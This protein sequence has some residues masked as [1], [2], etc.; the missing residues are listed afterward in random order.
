MCITIHVAK[1]TGVLIVSIR[2]KQVQAGLVFL[3]LLSAVGLSGCGADLGVADDPLALPGVA[4]HGKVHGGVYPIQKATIRLMETQSNGYGGAAKQLLQ[5]QSDNYGFFTFPDTGWSC[6]S[7]QFAYITVTGGFTI[8][9]ST[10]NNNVGQIGVIGNCGTVLANKAEI[11]GVEVYVSELSTIAAAYTLRSFISIDSTNAS[12]GNQIINISAPANNNAAAGKCS[13]G[14]VAAGLSHGFANAVNL[15]NSVSFNG[16]LPSGQALATPPTNGYGFVPQAEINTLANILQSCVDSG[17]GSAGSSYNSYVLGTSRCGDLFHWA[18]P[19]GGAA[20]TNTLQAALNMAQYPANNVVSL[21][22][23]Q[24]RATFFTPTMSQAPNDLSLSVFYF[25]QDFGANSTN[26]VVPVGL[27]LDANDDVYVLAASGAGSANT[28]T[29]VLGMTSNGSV[30]FSGPVS[31]T[32]LAPSGIATDANSNIWFTND[33]T[34]L[35]GGIYK[36]SSANG[37]ITT[38][39]L[40]PSAAGLAVDKS[41]NVWVSL[42]STTA[43]SIQ[44]FTSA[45]L[46]GVAVPAKKSNV[47]GAKL[48]SLT[49]DGSGNL[50]SL[51]ANGSTT[52][53][54]VFASG[55]TANLFSQ[56]LN[57]GAG[58]VAAPNA[59]GEVYIPLK[60]QIDDA[61]YSG[62]LTTN[63]QGTFNSTSLNAAAGYGAPNQSEVDGAGNVFFADTEA[64]GQIFEFIPSSSGNMNQGTLYS[65]FPCYPLGGGCYTPAVANGRSMQID[66]TGAMWYVAD[67]TVQVN[68]GNT[69]PIGVIIQTFGPGTPTWPLMS[70]QLPGV[71]PQ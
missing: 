63:N 16:V 11:D 23:L 17:G 53:A 26:L 6:D 69:Y 52:A 71:V 10:P 60:N 41:N 14:C 20:P 15:V 40:L 50:W 44:E 45:S 22:N 64:S 43:N 28:Q 70:V 49:I 67:G 62:N 46:V 8:N 12:T 25:T 33:S 27:T 13:P 7:N 39:T 30:L 34:G 48:Q 5:T 65:L 59:A 47:L 61:K 55:Y 51:N 57:G 42:D 38:G 4:I 37:V 29:G 19:P 9:A 56:G 35:T 36:A 68:P 66:S 3:S 2:S 21:F 18:T 31:T 54:V 58:N 1:T 32:L 24:P